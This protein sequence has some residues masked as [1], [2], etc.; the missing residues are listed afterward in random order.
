[1]FEKRVIKTKYKLCTS[2]YTSQ[3]LMT[4]DI[5]SKVCEKNISCV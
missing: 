3:Q 4:I 2:K 1:M 5:Q